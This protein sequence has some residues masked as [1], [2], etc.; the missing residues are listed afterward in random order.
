MSKLSKWLT[1]ALITLIVFGTVHF[2]SRGFSFES[3]NY[4][5]TGGMVYTKEAYM[6]GCS[7][8][9]WRSAGEAIY[10]QAEIDKYCA[11]TWDRG[12]AEYGVEGWSTELV[13]M[14]D[15]F[16]P[17]MTEFINQCILII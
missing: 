9:Y 16:T 11:C 15:N 3:V 13:N 2:I 7:D 17:K 5:P 1:G 4:S 14:G 8:G 6:K 10:S 12:V